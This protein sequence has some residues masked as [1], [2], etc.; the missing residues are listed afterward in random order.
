LSFLFIAGNPKLKVP[1]VCGADWSMD[2]L[3]IAKCWR[4]SI[5]EDKW[6]ELGRIKKGCNAAKFAFHEA[7]NRYEKHH[8]QIRLVFLPAKGLE[9]T[10]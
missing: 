7:T 5:L 3:T 4:Y 8:L 1:Y 6:R 9:A 10:F 2:R